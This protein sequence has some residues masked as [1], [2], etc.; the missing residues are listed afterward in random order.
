V[1]TLVHPAEVTAPELLEQYSGSL[2]EDERARIACFAL[3]KDR[4]ARLVARGA[5]RQALSAATGGAVAP[6]A[7]R[8]RYN[9]F[10]KP[11]VAYPAQA[12]AIPFNVSLTDG[13]VAIL[14]SSPG[15]ISSP[16]DVEV[17][18]DVERVRNIDDPVALAQH[19]FAP[20]EIDDLRAT[21]GEAQLDRFFRYWTLKESYI[22]ARG[23]GL[24]LPLNRF[25]FNL[26]GPI[27]IH[28]EPGFDSHPGEWVFQQQR[29]ASGHWLATAHHR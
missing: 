18:V 20:R 26:D 6:A 27:R 13:L 28:F 17:G 29:L 1:L 24:S 19:Y 8:F 15:G 22:K 23:L 12:A 4:H 7:F 9:D 11:L 21:P 14:I 5:L 16:G 10:G 2:A 25:W 3:E